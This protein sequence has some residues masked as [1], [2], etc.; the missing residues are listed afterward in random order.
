V[1]VIFHASHIVDIKGIDN[2]HVNNIGIGIVGGVISTQ[3]GSVIAITHLLPSIPL[4]N[5]IGTKMT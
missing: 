2:H 1:R 4:V 3:N 5:W